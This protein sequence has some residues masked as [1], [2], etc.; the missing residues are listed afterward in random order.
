LT[1]RPGGRVPYAV[2]AGAAALA[3]AAAPLGA[4]APAAT[5]APAAPP[6]QVCQSAEH[7]KTAATMSRGILDAVR[8]R[9]GQTPAVAVRVDAPSRD[10]SCWL[11][12]RRHFDAASVVKTI[13]LGALLRKAHTEHRWLTR[14]ER[15]LAWQMITESGNDAATA[16]WDDV[17]MYRLHRFL[18]L[19][20]MSETRLNPA[21]WGMTRITAHDETVLLQHLLLPNPVLTTRARRYEL[22]LM[23]RVIPAERWGVTA[24]APDDFTAHVKNGWAPLPAWGSPWWINSTGCFTHPGKDYTIVVLTGG[25]ANAATGIRT[26]EDIAF[27]INRDLN[28][29]ARAVVPYA[30]PNRSW[31]WPD[32]PLPPGGAAAAKRP[33]IAQL[34]PN[35]AL[36][37]R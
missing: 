34:H 31:A 33:A 21:A 24:G 35:Y 29:G 23:A 36:H 7:P 6:S 20:G 3:C 25:N 9:R 32:E 26:I 4:V 27:R 19:T 17:G 10:I 28:P 18:H 22:W 30:T 1:H 16:L 37:G 8:D 15:N 13:I 2:A 11:H 12:V 5:A 14:R